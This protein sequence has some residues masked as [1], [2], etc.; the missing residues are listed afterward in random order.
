MLFKVKGMGEPLLSI[1]FAAGTGRRHG[2]HN[3][4]YDAG[5]AVQVVNATRVLDA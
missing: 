2:T 3:A 1:H 4:A 5:N